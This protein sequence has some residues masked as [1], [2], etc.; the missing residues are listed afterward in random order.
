MLNNLDIELPEYEL[1]DRVVK[2]QKSMKIKGNTP[3]SP[4]NLYKKLADIY[5]FTENFIQYVEYN[6]NILPFSYSKV[7]APAFLIYYLTLRNSG[8]YISYDMNVK[9]VVTNDYKMKYFATLNFIENSY[10]NGTGMDIL[11]DGFLTEMAY[12]I[13]PKGVHMNLYIFKLLGIPDYKSNTMSF[14]FKNKI[15]IKNLSYQ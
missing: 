10:K 13:S 7:D 5:D 6:K 11:Y 8:K 12:I 15:D 2:R 9:S 1:Y 3:P 4:V 14:I